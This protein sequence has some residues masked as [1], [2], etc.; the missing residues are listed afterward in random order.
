[1]PKPYFRQVPDLLYANRAP[2]EKNISNYSKVKNLFKRAKL[3]DD[4]FS[5]LAYFTKYQIIGDER[6]DNVAEKVYDDPTLDWVILL[7]N[8]IT[9]IQTEWP[10]RES[11]YHNFLIDKYGSDEKLLEVHHYECTGVKNRSGSIIIEEGLHVP[12]GFG[13]TYFDY[14]TGSSVY[15][16]N[17]TKAV[18]NLDYENVIENKKRN[19]FILKTQYLNL[20]FND[21]DDI[22]EYK[23]GSTQYESET[24]KKTDNIRLYSN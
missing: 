17:I 20:V 19:I 3:R 7:A 6:P 5:N 21:L 4:I 14:R 23:K 1:M 10:M 11:S 16:T 12:V 15:A 2:G 13:V 9:N 8:N 22:M 18:T 24:L